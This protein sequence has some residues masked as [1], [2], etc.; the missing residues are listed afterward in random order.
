V[1]ALDRDGARRA[2]VR[3]LEGFRA[4]WVPCAL[5]ARKLE[6]DQRTVRAWIARGVLRG[7]RVRS[8]RDGRVRWF[9]SRS[10]LLGWL[11]AR[12]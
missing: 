8:Y 9:V 4:A 12:E 10:A 5:A 3:G 7:R 11:E 2:M 6:C 1:A